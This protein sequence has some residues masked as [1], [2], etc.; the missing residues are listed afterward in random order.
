MTHSVTLAVQL[1]FSF[2]SAE[3]EYGDALAEAIKLA[4]R[5]DFAS[6]SNETVLESVA[7]NDPDCGTT[8]ARYES[9]KA[10]GEYYDFDADVNS[11][12]I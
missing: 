6:I 1:N 3:K 7:V 10:L 11:V 4:F 9:R 2:D 8:I 12:N 5:P